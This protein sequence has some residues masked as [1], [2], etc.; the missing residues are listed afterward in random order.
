MT[1]TLVSHLREQLAELARSRVESERLR[2]AEKERL[3]IEVGLVLP[4][5]EGRLTKHHSR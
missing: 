1:F 2:A 3:E 4:S 5:R